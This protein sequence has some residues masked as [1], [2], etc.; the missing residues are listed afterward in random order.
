[1]S[2]KREETRIIKDYESIE[3]TMYY[4][5]KNRGKGELID[6][7][8][9]IKWKDVKRVEGRNSTYIPKYLKPYVEKHDNDLGKFTIILNEFKNDLTNKALT[10]IDSDF[11]KIQNNVDQ[12]LASIHILFIEYF[13]EK[14]KYL[15][16]NRIFELQIATV[17]ELIT[18]LYRNI[19]VE[20]QQEIREFQKR[21]REKEKEEKEQ[22]KEND[23]KREERKVVY[24]EI[25]SKDL[26]VI[27]LIP[28][29]FKILFSILNNYTENTIKF[30]E[31]E[32]IEENDIERS[33]NA[34]REGIRNAK[35]EKLKRRLTNDYDKSRKKYEEYHKTKRE[36]LTKQYRVKLSKALE[37]IEK[38]AVKYTKKII[39]EIY[40]YEENSFLEYKEGKGLFG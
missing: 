2:Q 18:L 11:L 1:M 32:F 23:K 17:K 33:L 13:L 9:K 28:S 4:I 16:E 19:T 26:L 22:R 12:S 6:Y 25:K 20:K 29:G 21:E 30:S 35:D 5:V 36:I 37:K 24:Y 34:L 31:I 38:D 39:K 7:L 8:L 15:K 40:K 10:I 14:L 27:N 3:E